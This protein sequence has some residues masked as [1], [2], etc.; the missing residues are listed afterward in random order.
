MV[1]GDGYYFRV[2]ADIYYSGLDSN[3][4]P[5]SAD[6]YPDVFV[7]RAPVD[8]I[9]ETQTFVSKTIA[10]EKGPA[11]Y[12]TTALFLADR[13]DSAVTSKLIKRKSLPKHF[14]Y[15]ELHECSTNA[16]MQELN[17]GYGIVNHVG[18]SWEEGLCLSSGCPDY[19][20]IRT[21]HANT[22]TNSSR[23][24]IFYGAG[25]LSNAIDRQHTIAKSFM[26]NSN[27]GAVAYIGNSRYGISIPG[28]PGNGP[29]DNYNKSFYNSLF[30]K[31]IDNLGQA[32]ADSK[33]ALVSSCTH[34]A[35]ASYRYLQYGLNLL[36]D[37]ETKIWTSKDTVSS[38]LSVTAQNQLT[39]CCQ[40][41]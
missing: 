19:Y 21:T 6:L 33:V 20:R 39:I 18:H 9:S 1:Y 28:D 24:P 11:G 27:G 37:P 4:S 25:C 31:G 29:S 36:G 41:T 2:P 35:D 8:T 16:A 38:K 30:N 22:L 15:T 10:Y 3:T 23:N 5:A 32:F 17:L 14:S 13:D 26:L 7:G 40:G 34:P 12:E